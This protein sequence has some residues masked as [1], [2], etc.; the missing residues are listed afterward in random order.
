VSNSLARLFL[1]NTNTQRYTNG[2]YWYLQQQQSTRAGNLHL[3]TSMSHT[4]TC[5]FPQSSYPDLGQDPTTTGSCG[6]L[7]S[8][9]MGSYRDPPARRQA[10]ISVFAESSGLRRR[11][12]LRGLFPRMIESLF[13]LCNSCNAPS[14]AASSYSGGCIRRCPVLRRAGMSPS[15]VWDIRVRMSHPGTTRSI[16]FKCGPLSHWQSSEAG[17]ARPVRLPDRAASLGRVP[18]VTAPHE[19]CRRADQRAGPRDA[20]AL[21]WRPAVPARGRA[22]AAPRAAALPLH[23][24]ARRAARL[25]PGL[26]RGAP[27]GERSATGRPPRVRARAGSRR[28]GRAPM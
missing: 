14:P 9:G 23:H 15:T 4:V 1:T 18:P 3:C 8:T 25:R 26:S 20:A 19:P 7:L 22:G 2:Y 21:R 13:R 5:S 10:L 12:I 17:T 28:G 11:T 27:P 16:P 6:S 24:S